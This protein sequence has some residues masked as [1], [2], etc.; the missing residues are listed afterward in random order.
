VAT[1]PVFEQSKEDILPFERA[2]AKAMVKGAQLDLSA[3]FGPD[4]GP[5]ISLPRYPWQQKEFRFQHT[6][7]SFGG[8]SAHLPLVGM[9]YRPDATEWYSNVDTALYPELKDH[10]VG[11]RT[12][13]PGSA[14]FE[15]AI[16]VGR[17][18]LDIDNLV[19]NDF[20]LLQPLI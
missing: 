7:E 8:D 10:R 12:I 3:T 17:Q 14:F 1:V 20:Q 4:P 9:R 2:V 19:L 11:S 16:S 6:S 15:I 13:F 5:A 18:W